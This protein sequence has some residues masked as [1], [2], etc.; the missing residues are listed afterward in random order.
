MNLS[1]DVL[2][3]APPSPGGMPAPSRPAV[4]LRRRSPAGHLARAALVAILAAGL[5]GCASL[6]KE[7][8]VSLA[9]VSLASIGI[10]G[11]TARVELEVYNP[12]SFGL[13]AR[14][15]EYGLSFDPEGRP[16]SV[17]VPDDAWRTLATGRSAEEVRLSGGE[18]TPVTILVPFSYS[19]I[20]TAF[21]R[22]LRDG[23]LRYRFS[24]AFT[25]G[26]PIGDLR[27]PF[28]RNGL[29]DP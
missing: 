6:V 13:N 27:I 8:S 4:H 12:N 11:A 10:S 21:S 18:T 14:S 23:A 24:G 26:S 29:L 22:L 16:D 28:D 9:Q 1:F 17:D 25:V 7:P 20:G 5:S 19:E 3:P 2:R 15:V